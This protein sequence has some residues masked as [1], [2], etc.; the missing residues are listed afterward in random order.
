MVHYRKVVIAFLLIAGT[1]TAQ[2]PPRGQPEPAFNGGRPR[3]VEASPGTTGL[4]YAEAVVRLSGTRFAIIAT[5][6]KDAA[7]VLVILDTVPERVANFETSFEANSQWESLRAIVSVGSSIVMAGTLARTDG[8]VVSA[9]AMREIGVAAQPLFMPRGTLIA[10]STSA[11]RPLILSGTVAAV[12]AGGGVARIWQARNE[13]ATGPQC[14][15]AILHRLDHAKG[16]F[17][18]HDRLDLAAV[19]GQT[20]LAAYYAMPVGPLPT[21]PP[22][23]QAVIVG[24]S[25]RLAPGDVAYVCITRVI[26]SAGLLSIDRSFG[27]NGVFTHGAAARANFLIRGVLTDAAGRLVVPVDRATG[28]P[29]LTQL[30]GLVLRLQPNGTLDPTFGGGAVT[31]AV[32]DETVVSGAAISSNGVVQVAGKGTDTAGTRP[33]VFYF[34]PAT[35]AQQVVRLDLTTLPAG[36]SSAEFAAVAA[37]PAGGSLAV[38]AATSSG[39]LGHTLVARLAGDRQTLDLVEYYHRDFDHFFMTSD[40]GEIG[41]LDSGAFAGWQRTGEAFAAYPLS[42]VGALDVCRFFSATF[43]PKSSHFYTT[44]PVECDGL[45]TGIVWKYEGLV[46]SLLGAPGAGICPTGTTRLFRMY[47]DGQGN[48]PNHRYT[49][50]DALRIEQVARGWVMEGSGS[51]PTFACAPY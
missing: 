10:P 51:P 42:A 41:K 2:Y 49:V 4:D 26:D 50:E 40:R 12:D 3:I 5:R 22:G 14:G 1:A 13:Y 25:C 20:C 38:G 11:A 43:A 7:D 8:S 29:P 31:V 15:N 46:Y 19:L 37:L 17:V 21:D 44:D 9:L 33:F 23:A 24:A 32:G 39:T 30:A 34:D 47:N 6:P 45:K 16:T 35:G 36:Y 28:D 27:T 18:E 48:A